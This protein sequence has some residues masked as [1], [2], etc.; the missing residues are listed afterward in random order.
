MQNPTSRRTEVEP[1]ANGLNPYVLS[2]HA[3]LH[4]I[5]KAA[6][7]TVPVSAQRRRLTIL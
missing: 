1:V 6:D 2:L 5:V 3:A 4:F 7:I